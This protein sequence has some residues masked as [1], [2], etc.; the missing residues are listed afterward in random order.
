M[1]TALIAG[2]S[3]LVG[4]LLLQ[5]LLATPEYDR[6]VAVGRRP[7]SVVHPKLTQVAVEFST[8]DKVIADLKCDD[9]FCCLGTTIRQAG[10]Q[11]AFRAVDHAAVLAFAW[12][13]RRNGAQSFLWSQRS[14]RMRGRAF[15]TTA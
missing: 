10:S 4:G 5:Q 12:A 6:V 7:L 1:R 3:G 9:A 14:G 8:L 15:S 11:T 2:G 13:A